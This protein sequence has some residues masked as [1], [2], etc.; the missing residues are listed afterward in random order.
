MERRTLLRDELGLRANQSAVADRKV[1]AAHSGRTETV[2]EGFE[3]TRARNRKEDALKD[4]LAK[5]VQKSHGEARRRN[6]KE[7]D[8]HEREQFLHRYRANFSRSEIRV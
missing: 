3:Q 7:F 4:V 1:S 2:L 8:L 5:S 6:E